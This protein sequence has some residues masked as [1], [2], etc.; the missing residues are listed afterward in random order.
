MKPFVTKRKGNFKASSMPGEP[1]KKFP[2]L[3]IRSIKSTSQIWMFQIL[4]K[5]PKKQNIFV[6]SLAVS[7]A[8]ER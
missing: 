6:I 5:K 7:R 2:F 4:V 3:K 1:E 8:L